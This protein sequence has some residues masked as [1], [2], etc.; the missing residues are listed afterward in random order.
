MQNTF[1]LEVDYYYHI[2]YVELGLEKQELCQP[3]IN[4]D[5]WAVAFSHKL[6]FWGLHPYEFHLGLLIQSFR[7]CKCFKCLSL[8]FAVQY[9]TSRAG[10]PN[11]FF[12]NGFL[13]EYNINEICE[14]RLFDKYNISVESAATTLISV[15]SSS[16]SPREKVV[17]PAPKSARRLGSPLCQWI[18]PTRG[19]AKLVYGLGYLGWSSAGNSLLINRN[20][21]GV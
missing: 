6:C 21:R 2:P 14:R 7:D 3:C 12:L 9:V 1:S 11:M 15:C 19:M 20:L 16:R 4:I 10:L 13:C 8:K 18:W 5:P 17:F